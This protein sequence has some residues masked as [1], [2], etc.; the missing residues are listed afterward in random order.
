MVKE[1]GA[2]K[3]KNISYWDMD[4]IQV[5]DGYDMRSIPDLTRDNIKILVDEHNELVNLVNKIVDR[6]WLEGA[7]DE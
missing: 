1:S 5:P 3:L 6:L 7:G 4:T 2:V